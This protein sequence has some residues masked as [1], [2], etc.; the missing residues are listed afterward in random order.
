MII[1]LSGSNAFLLKSEQDRLIAEFLREHSDMGLQRIDGEETEYDT[2]REAV[3]SLPFLATKKLVILRA[4]SANKMF[5]EQAEKLLPEVDKSI[6]VAIIEPK[7]DK[8]LSYYKWLKK[9][10]EFREYNELDEM[11]LGRWLTEQAKTFG[12]S[13]S[14]SDARY[15]IERV[16]FNQ[17]LLSNEI[18]KLAAYSEKIDRTNI[19]LLTEPNPQSTVFELLDAA[20]VGNHKRVLK[21][22]QE[23]RASKVEP[24]QILAMLAW[25][26]HI[27]ALI[28]TAGN[29]S[30]DQIARDAKINPFVLRKSRAVSN[31]LS[32]DKLRRLVADL[33]N[34]DLKLKSVS[35]DADDALQAYLLNI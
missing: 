4:P 9:N 15:L 19:D 7:L 12:A 33:T 32:A 28:K 30:D 3:E 5:V 35:I 13:I 2:I 34:L 10:T 25:Q 16:G 18:A 26:L 17:Q 20:F 24:Q 14:S 22:Y 6:D 21:L 27:L 29:R 23:Q 1:T 31:K 11:G 8:R